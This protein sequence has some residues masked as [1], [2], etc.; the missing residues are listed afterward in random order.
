MEGRYDR[1]IPV[2]GE[3]GQKRIQEAVVGIAGCG[4]LG[5][6][7]ITQLTAA[8]VSGFILCDPQT[9]DVTNL[10][11]QFIYYPADYRP[12]AEIAAQWVL[13]LNPLAMVEAHA[14][15]ICEENRA[16]FRHCDVIIDCL[17]SFEGRMVLSDLSEETGIPLIHGGVSGMHGQ[18]AVCIPGKTPSLR[19]MIGT[20]RDPE[21]TVPSV[22]AAVSNIASMEALEALKL[23]SGIGTC[24][25][26]RLVTVDMEHWTTETVDFSG[27]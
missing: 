26:G 23:L 17:D 15:A 5:V 6:N 14:E 1:Q 22:G 9:P 11:R 25:A 7:V 20:M 2:F 27:E 21:G 24:N 8:G 10:N 16:V 12:K 13:A 3:D 4:G 19:D 18:I